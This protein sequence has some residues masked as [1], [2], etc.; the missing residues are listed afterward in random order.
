MAKVVYSFLLLRVLFPGVETLCRLG[1]GSSTYNAYLDQRP[2]GDAMELAGKVNAAMAALCRPKCPGL[3]MFRNPTA[4]NAMLITANSALKL[5]YRP[6][7]FTTVYDSYGDGGIVAILAH[8]VGHAIDPTSPASWMKKD[9][10]P[11]LRADAWAGCALA[12]INLSS[13]DLKAGLTTLSKYPSPSHP[14]WTVRVPV[15]RL[16]YTQCSGDGATFDNAARE[17]ID[18]RGATKTTMRKLPS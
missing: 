2:T 15:L 3:A 13:H 14:E 5:V 7:F 4:S 6:D 18:G 9:W 11:E 8:Q 12:K 16:G 17:G 1:P 10:T